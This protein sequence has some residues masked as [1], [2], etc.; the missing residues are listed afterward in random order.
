MERFVMRR[1]LIA[2]AAVSAATLASSAFA[3]FSFTTDTSTDGAFTVFLIRAIND[4]AGTGTELDGYDVSYA[5]N[6][7]N[8]AV[9]G[10]SDNDF[11]S[12]PDTADLIN[13][14][15]VAQKSF[16]RVGNPTTTNIVSATPSASTEPSP[17]GS[18]N[19]WSLAAISTGSEVATG[20]GAVIARLFVTGPNAGGDI[21]GQIGGN[22]GSAVPFSYHFGAGVGPGDTVAPVVVVNPA[23]AVI[24]IPVDTGF[25]PVDISAT[26]NVGVT[27]LQLAGSLPAQI[28]DNVS[29]T[30]DA[31]GPLSMSGTGF[32][33]ADIGSYTLTFTAMDAAGNSGSGSFLLN[34]TAVPEPTTLA[35][36]AG[37]GLLA[38]R[39]RK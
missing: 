22:E 39:R 29:I 4:G 15:N 11:D 1:T 30:G 35:A 9:F 23:S 3:G 16:L 31:D 33:A 34:V 37:V 2:A 10:T 28:A 21:T 17:W 13:I 32:T 25:G 24:V 8:N 27:S 18:I 14:N 38:L 36:L 20:T 6:P 12:I 26:D 5:L 19:S 7:G